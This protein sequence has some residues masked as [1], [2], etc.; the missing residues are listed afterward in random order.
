MNRLNLVL[1]AA[2]LGLATTAVIAQDVPTLTVVNQA[3]E[4]ASVHVIGPTS[5]Y[6]DVTSSRTVNVS[7]GVYYLK[8]RYCSSAGNCRYSKTDPFTVTQTAY[9]VSAITVTLHSVGGNLHAEPE[10]DQF[11]N[12]LGDANVGLDARHGHMADVMPVQGFEEL[13]H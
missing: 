9:Q 10:L 7:G 5:G 6:I 12:R 8:V 3:G 13:R 1:V 4:S 2:L 11:E